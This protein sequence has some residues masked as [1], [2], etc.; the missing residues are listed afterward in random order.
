MGD[1]QYYVYIITNQYHT[2][3]YTGVTGDLQ[4]RIAEH[5]SGKGGGFSNKYHL[6]KLIYYE[7]GDDINRAI[8]REKQ[9]KGGSGRKRS[10]WSKV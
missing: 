3:L 4:R 2:V 8:A 6:D 7:E 10:S 1:K 9:I 5:K